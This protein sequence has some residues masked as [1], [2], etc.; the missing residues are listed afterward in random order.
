MDVEIKKLKMNEK[1]IESI[2]E[3]DKTF[4]LDMD[5][6]NNSWYMQRYNENF[7]VTV[8]M[9]NKVI[10]GYFI[11]YGIKEALYNKIRNLE[12]DNDYTFENNDIDLKS[13][14]KYL[15]SVLVKKEYREYSFLLILELERQFRLLDKVVAL[16]VSREGKQMCEKY[17]SFIGNVNNKANV[18]VKK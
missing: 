14:I 11:F 18:Y 4:Y 2:I 9:V 8:L 6:S 5:Y 16:A 1:V 15:A 3:V 12:Y 10:V 17:M 7:E 13:N